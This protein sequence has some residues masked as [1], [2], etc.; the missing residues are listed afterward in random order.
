MGD[1]LVVVGPGDGVDDLLLVEV[2]GPLDLRHV[3][4]QVPVLH[5]LGLQPSRI[6][7]V[8]LSFAPIVQYDAH[9]EL[10]HASLEQMT[11]DA[12]LAQRVNHPPG[13]VLFH[14]HN[15]AANCEQSV[16]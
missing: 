4:D 5:H 15:V 14:P 13:P 12:T 2:L 16:H 10:I 3:T 1:G 11:V 6:V 9:P 8:P 7:G